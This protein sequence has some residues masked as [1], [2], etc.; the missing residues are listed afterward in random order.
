ML[1]YSDYLFLIRRS[2]HYETQTYNQSIGGEYSPNAYKMALL[3]PDNFFI[4]SVV[5]TEELY[6]ILMIL[7]VFD[8]HCINPFSFGFGFQK[9]DFVEL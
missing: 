2:I 1:I 7:G 5:V 9:L 8:T 3:K 6:V 4:A